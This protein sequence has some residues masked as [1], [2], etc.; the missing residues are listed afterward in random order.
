MP[1]FFSYNPQLPTHA[2]WVRFLTGDT[3]ATTPELDD[4]EIA[5]LLKDTMVP[6]T[7]IATADDWRSYRHQVA[8]KAAEAIAAKHATDTDV[9]F[10][11]Q[12]VAMSAKFAQYRMLAVSLRAVAR[13]QGGGVVRTER[14]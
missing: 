10:D 13:S 8:A 3:K 7:T 14:W 4:H 5:E 2:D 12:R 11:N 1:V 9:S 6:D